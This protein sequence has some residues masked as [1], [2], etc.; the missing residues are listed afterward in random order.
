VSFLLFSCQTF[1]NVW[2]HFSVFFTYYLKF[3]EFYFSNYYQYLLDYPSGSEEDDS[4][5]V[6]EGPCENN[7]LIASI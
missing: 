4:N 2:F 5:F 3:I 6:V 7:N 1:C